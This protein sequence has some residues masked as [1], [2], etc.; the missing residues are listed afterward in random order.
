LGTVLDINQIQKIL[1]HRY[2][3]LLIDRVVE[4]EPRK[5]AVGIKNVSINEEFFVGHFPGQP[6]MPGVLQIEAMAQLAGTLLMQELEG[7]SKLP[8]LMS[9]DKV[10]FRRA[11]V[12]G[13]QLV[14]EAEATKLGTNR[15]EVHTRAKVDGKVV[16]EAQIRFMLV[17]ADPDAESQTTDR[18]IKVEMEVHKTAV[19]EPGA[20]LGKGVRIGPHCV[21]GSNASIGDGTRLFSHVVVVGNTT[22]GKN[23]KI[24]QNAV[25]GTWPQDVSFSGKDTEVVIGDNNV[26][27]EFVTIHCGTYKA[28]LVTRLGND[29]YIMA[30]SHVAHD[31]EIGNG[32]IMANGVQLGGHVRLEDRANVGGLA[33]LH[34]FVTVG[35]LAFV[36]GLTRVVRDVPPY[37]TVEGNP[38]KVRCVNVV[39]CNRNGV[40]RETINA[41]KHAYRVLYRSQIPVRDAIARME[42][43]NASDEVAELIAFLRNSAKGRQGRA[44]EALRK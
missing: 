32:V 43:T 40:K 19:I 5:R 2:P 26:I 24:Y 38:S 1:P 37:M 31:C 39:G 11:V 36:G 7:D 41:L 20:R 35:R 8:F 34:H 42:E 4:F 22:V 44:R 28:D 23:N 17:D 30:Y 25:I 16:A 29:N 18:R 6:V 13:D 12:P 21:V 33:A 9:I 3:F 15:G 14:L 10:K 27:R